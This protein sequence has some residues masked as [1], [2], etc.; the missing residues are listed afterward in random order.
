M[1]EFLNP[2]ERQKTKF[3]VSGF[4]FMWATD[5][6][7]FSGDITEIED[8]KNTFLQECT[9]FVQANIHSSARCTNVK[10]NI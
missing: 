5:N 8:N 3:K 1:L 9:A 6:V 4:F 2:A 7:S 10:S